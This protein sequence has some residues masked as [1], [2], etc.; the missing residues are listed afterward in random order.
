MKFL[1]VLAYP[2]SLLYGCIMLVRNKM[3][4]WHL[5]PSKSYNLPVICVG[6]LSVGG[7]GKTPHTEY[8]IKLLMNN[9]KVGVLSRGYKRKTKGFFLAES[10][11]LVTDVGD[12][13]LQMAHK[14]D[15]IKIAVCE[16]RRKGIE[17]LLRNFPDLDVIILDDAFQHRYV[18]PGLS[19][20]LSDYSNLYTNDFVLP[21]GNLREFISGA[22]RAHII[23]VTKSPKVLSPIVSKDIEAKLSLQPHQKLYFTY[24]KHG[25]FIPLYTD[26]GSEM[27]PKVYVIL[28]FAGIANTYPLEEHLKTKCDDLRV[29][30]FNDHY[31][32]KEEDALALLQKFKDLYS[33]NKIMVTTEKDAKRLENS[34]F[35]NIFRNIPLF[36]IPI[37]IEFH[38][39]YKT[40]FDNQILNCVRKNKTNR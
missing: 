26:N 35:K 14:F 7:T 9:F 31:Q 40:D 25:N 18:K 29:I 32:Y 10:A 12:E 38:N 2:L 28:L 4:D 30:K 8:I 6:N 34:V 22:H 36:Y 23:C 20:I 16:S 24:I 27:P 33:V 1:K 39:K 15:N 17:I 5:L 19:I 21:T 37:E 13:V 3:F 11:S